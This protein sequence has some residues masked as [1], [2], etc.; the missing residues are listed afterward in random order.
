MAEI[1]VGEQ[2]INKVGE[3]GKIISVNKDYIQVQFG[4]RVASFLHDAFEKGFLVYKNAE[5]QNKIDELLEENKQEELRSRDSQ[6]A[7]FLIGL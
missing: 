5:L 3:M 6:Q 1:M 4:D 2:V 7:V